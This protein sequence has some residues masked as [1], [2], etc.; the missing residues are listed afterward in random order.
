MPSVSA[1]SSAQSCTFQRHDLPSQLTPEASVPPFSRTL[2]VHTREG[3]AVIPLAGYAGPSPYQLKPISVVP[4]LGKL[5]G[6]PL[7][8]DDSST[9]SASS[10]PSMPP[11]PSSSSSSSSSVSVQKQLEDATT[12]PLQRPSVP[13]GRI[14]LLNPHSRPLRVLGVSI[15]EDLFEV[16]PDA[17]SWLLRPGEKRDI[18][19]IFLNATVPSR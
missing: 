11:S 8:A 3:D 1:R 12:V 2:Q 13:V 14:S 5:P 4:Y 15:L 7:A 10:A 17:S 16:V 19:Q 9:T 6:F 18:A